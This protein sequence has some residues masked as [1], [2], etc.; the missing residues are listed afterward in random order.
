M[1]IWTMLNVIVDVN[2]SVYTNVQRY[3]PAPV[4]VGT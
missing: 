2:V 4:K 1:F 3:N